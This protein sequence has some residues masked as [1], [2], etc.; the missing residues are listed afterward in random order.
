[1]VASSGNG[2]NICV[3]PIKILQS[4]CFSVSD[5]CSSFPL[6]SCY[7]ATRVLKTYTYAGHA[8]RDV[9]SYTCTTTLLI[10]WHFLH[11]V[12]REVAADRFWP[13]NYFLY[14]FGRRGYERL[15]RKILA[16]P[17]APAIIL[18]NW[19]SPPH[20]NYSFWSAPILKHPPN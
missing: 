4:S 9:R 16:F 11:L 20:F 19:W 2:V 14:L 1:V 6:F 17:N 5:C 13:L 15:I 12:Q 18:V 10:D 7:V 3:P 8:W